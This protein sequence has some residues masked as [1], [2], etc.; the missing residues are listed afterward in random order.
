VPDSKEAEKALLFL[1]SQ[2]IDGIKTSDDQMINPRS[3]ACAI[4]ALSV[5]NQS[6][7]RYDGKRRG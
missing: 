6:S 4:S 2:L 5:S 1:P 7:M 3:S